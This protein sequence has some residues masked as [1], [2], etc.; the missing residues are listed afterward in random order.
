MNWLC[1]ALPPKWSYVI[2]QLGLLPRTKLHPSKPLRSLPFRRHW[3]I[4][5]PAGSKGPAQ[6][7]T[8]CSG[9]LYD[10]QAPLPLRCYNFFVFCG[11]QEWSWMESA[12]LDFSTGPLK[13]LRGN[14][15]QWC[16]KDPIQ[17]R[18]HLGSAWVA[19]TCKCC[20]LV[21]PRWNICGSLWKPPRND[22]TWSALALCLAMRIPKQNFPCLPPLKRH[23]RNRCKNGT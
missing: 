17:H 14:A 9:G 20:S 2:Q 16:C 7:Q 5:G 10:T 11:Y 12:W 15:N 22:V 18:R 23:H 8:C 19:P 21:E 13:S 3:S 6:E 1:H 4:A